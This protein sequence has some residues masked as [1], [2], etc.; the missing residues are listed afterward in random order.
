VAVTDGAYK[1]LYA[2][3][4]PGAAEPAAATDGANDRLYDLERDPEESLDLAPALPVAAR[5][6]RRLA[7]QGPLAGLA[8]EPPR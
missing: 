2:L 8:T 7:A 4:A 3:P 6:L 5:Y 1:Y